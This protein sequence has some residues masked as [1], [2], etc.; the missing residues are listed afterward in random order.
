MP[1]RKK[2][3]YLYVKN[4]DVVEQLS[5][6]ETDRCYGR[7]LKGGPN[8]FLADFLSIVDESPVLL[9]GV[10]NSFKKMVKSNIKAI[11]FA[12][13]L[14]INSPLGRSLALGYMLIRGLKETIFFKPDRVLSGT[15]G[16]LLWVSWIVAK[17]YGCALIYSCHNRLPSA[18]TSKHFF[19]NIK[20]KID[21]AVIKHAAGIICH[22]PYLYDQLQQLGI[23]KQKLVEFDSQPDLL[24]VT[25]KEIHLV[26][27]FFSNYSEKM[28][29]ILYVGRMEKDKGVFDLLAA[30]KQILRTD[31]LLVLLYI[32]TGN[33]LPVLKMQVQRYG[34]SDQVVFL[35]KQ[36]HA[37]I[38][39][40]LQKAYVL[41][42]PTRD[43]F[44]EGR[45][46]SAMEG[47]FYHVPVIAPNFGPFPYL[48][49]HGENGLLYRP[50]S[51]S[52]L[53]KQLQLLLD[54]KELR[55]KLSKER[56]SEECQFSKLSF[57]QAFCKALH[58]AEHR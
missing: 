39:L 9:V 11:V 34:L 56:E 4:G 18:A 33:A 47:L 53:G 51:A 35:G 49:T 14:F 50:N 13:T 19:Q 25:D 26:D 40:F 44:P 16:V 6:L 29:F 36:P 30:C 27:S 52:D 5:E 43:N 21:R 3:R 17:L 7:L 1:D 31:P 15:R 20:S 12:K 58:I 10:G 38:G 24:P 41:V 48:V 54:N 22:G 45:C 46:M 57:A 37:L 8:A 42:T 28:R 23:P 55:A 32:G 2:F